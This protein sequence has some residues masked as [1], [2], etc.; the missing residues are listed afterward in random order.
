VPAGATLLR[1]KQ[2]FFRIS[3]TTPGAFAREFL[4]AL[5]VSSPIY[6]RF[7]TGATV[8]RLIWAG[9]AGDFIHGLVLGPCAGPAVRL[10]LRS[11]KS[12]VSFAGLIILFRFPHDHV[13]VLRFDIIQYDFDD[14]SGCVHE[15]ICISSDQV[16]AFYSTYLGGTFN[17]W[18]GRH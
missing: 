8:T 7:F 5:A 9:T 2:V 4:A 15:E 14:R 11:R 13:L 16:S 17:E 12:V 1:E 10:F 6:V 18:W 3:R